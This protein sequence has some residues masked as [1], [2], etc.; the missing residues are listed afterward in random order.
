M[1]LLVIGPDQRPDDRD[2]NGNLNADEPEEVAI[3]F[4]VERFEA[5]VHPFPQAGR[6]PRMPISSGSAH[7]FGPLQPDCTSSA[8]ARSMPL[9]LAGSTHSSTVIGL[10]R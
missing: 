5:S 2:K 8:A 1:G 3:N 7:V 4:L 10:Q 6:L 9:P